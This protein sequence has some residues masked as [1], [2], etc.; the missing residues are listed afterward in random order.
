MGKRCILDNFRVKAYLRCSCTLSTLRASLALFL[1][2]I[3][4]SIVF[5]R[6]ILDKIYIYYSSSYVSTKL[7]FDGQNPCVNMANKLY[8]LNADLD[9]ALD[10]GSRARSVL[11]RYSRNMK[12]KIYIYHILDNFRVKACL[13]KTALVALVFLF[14]STNTVEAGCQQRRIKSL[15]EA[16]GTPCV[17]GNNRCSLRRLM[18][19]GEKDENPS[20]LENFGWKPLNEHKWPKD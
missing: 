14:L 19:E 1:K 4:N 9:P 12:N 13:Y 7:R 11:T 2:F 17:W 18:P 5:N 6:S 15:C 20:V 10:A 8:L 3:S 16:P